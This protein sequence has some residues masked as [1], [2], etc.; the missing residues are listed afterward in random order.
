MTLTVTATC[1]GPV[2]ATNSGSTTLTMQSVAHTLTVT[3]NPPNPATVASGG[4]TSLTASCSDS[5]TGHT[6][7]IWS[8]NDGGAGGSFS[9]SA[10]VQNPSYTAAA[11]TT[12]SNRIVTL[13][14]TATCDGPIP[15]TGTA[16]AD[17]IVLPA[18]KANFRGQPTRGKLPLTVSFTDTSIG[19]PFSWVWTFGDRDTSDE[20][21]PVH[22][23]A[24]AGRRDVS[25]RIESALGSD[26][27]Q[28]QRYITVSFKDVPITPE[29][30]ADF[31]ALN[32]ILACVDADIVQGYPDGTYQPDVAVTR[33]QIAVY[34]A[35][36]VAGGDANIPPGPAEPT[37][38]DVP[39]DYWAYSYIEY[40]A[41]HKIVLGYANGTYRPELEIDR[42]Q[43]AAFIARA[44]VHPTG[45]DGLVSYTP[46]TTPNFPD[47]PTKH[48]AYKYVEYLYQQHVVRGY[49]DGLYHPDW[50][51]TRDQLAVYIARAFVL[52]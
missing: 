9:P 5:R 24:T 3:A 1:N 11:N 34:I 6:I 22:D 12:D 46:P 2:P 51:L 47:V 21:N 37:F 19:S 25:L 27:E 26:I 44:I 50:T 20:Q 49:P 16:S 30:P 14:V 40:V 23:Y 29:D 10:S 42:A 45:D 18:L 15:L 32:Q 8:W 39:T 36:S 28:K 7:A 48:W 35:R 31:W 43:M 13:T 17:L 41:S 4:S 52:P 33:D 38:R